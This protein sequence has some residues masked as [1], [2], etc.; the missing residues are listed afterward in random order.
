MDILHK[1]F[2]I[3]HRDSDPSY[4]W[5][6]DVVSF[7]HKG[8]DRL[9]PSNIRLKTIEIHLNTGEKRTAV[10]TMSLL[11]YIFQRYDVSKP[12]SKFADTIEK[13]LM[14][15]NVHEEKEENKE[16]KEHKAKETT[17]FLFIQVHC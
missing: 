13:V 7:L 15:S 11:R 1:M 12:C 10:T 9:T 3:I 16:E 2:N 4:V 6:D 17:L 14:K 8:G 5:F